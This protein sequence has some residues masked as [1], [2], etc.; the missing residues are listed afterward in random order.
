VLHDPPREMRV[1]GLSDQLDAVRSRADD[2]FATALTFK[3]VLG[4]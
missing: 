3:L 1:I 2:H 4:H